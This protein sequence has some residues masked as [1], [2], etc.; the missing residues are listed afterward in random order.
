MYNST[1]P[2]FH[3]EDAFVQSNKQHKQEFAWHRGEGS[4]QVPKCS[5]NSWYKNMI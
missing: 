1:I 5:L 2:Q 4:D 3:L